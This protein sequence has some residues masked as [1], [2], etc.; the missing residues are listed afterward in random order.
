VGAQVTLRGVG[1]VS[2]AQITN[3]GTIQANVA[4]QTLDLGDSVTNAG[5]MSAING[6][7][8]V[9]RGLHNQ[10]GKSVT[11]D[12]AQLTLRIGWDNA[13]TISGGQRPAR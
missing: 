8:L 11:A 3:L 13:G 2:I 5:S 9:V 6:G 1:L 10:A 7:Q 12:A 4:G